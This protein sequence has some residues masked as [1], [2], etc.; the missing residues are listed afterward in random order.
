[1]PLT[2]STRAE[3]MVADSVAAAHRGDDS[4]DRV[5]AA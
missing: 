5:A 2:T 3:P 4:T 1:M